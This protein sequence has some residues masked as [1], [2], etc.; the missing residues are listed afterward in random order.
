M[1]IIQT[2]NNLVSVNELIRGFRKYII[3][4]K[5]NNKVFVLL[6]VKNKYYLQSLKENT[7]LGEYSDLSIAL[8][9]NDLD[10]FRAFRSPS[11]FG[12]WLNE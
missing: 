10:N 6:R 7:I 5:V 11:E 9:E 8:Q 2:K 12:G 4:T 1:R 3:A